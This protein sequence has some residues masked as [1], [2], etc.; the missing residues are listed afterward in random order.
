MNIIQSWQAYLD[1]QEYAQNTITLYANTIR[2]FVKGMQKKPEMA[3]ADDVE[4]WM[5]KHK[6]WAPT[7][8]KYQYIALKSFYA[9]LINKKVISDDPTT[10]LPSISGKRHID[11]STER[12]KEDKVYSSEDLIKL[13]EFDD[14]RYK[15]QVTRDK[16]IIALMAASGMRGAE[17][18]W[19]N[20]GQIRNRNGNEIF[21]LRKGQNIRKIVVAEFAFHYIDQYLATRKD[22]KD[23]DP[24]FVSRDGN[25]L[26]P[27]ALWYL[28]AMKQRKCGLRT[29]T[30]NIRYTVLNAVAR[31]ADPVVARD[32]AGQKSI[33]VTNG[34]LVSNAQER[35]SAIAA[36]PW[37]AKLKK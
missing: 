26:T 33:S 12:G 35:A 9:Y 8:R 30:H 36:L 19:L 18:C 13:I 17:V 34:Y 22:A 24:L 14:M 5:L 3:T 20:I 37:G 2:E 11:E 23:D 4:A 15:G 16:A 31:D 27:N 25:R 28:L 32:I 29:G 21:A 6:N 7:T 10:I 1:A